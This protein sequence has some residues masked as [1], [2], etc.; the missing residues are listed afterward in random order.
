MKLM[1][2][3]RS[4]PALGV[5]PSSE[6]PDQRAVMTYM[7]EAAF[8]ATLT[9]TPDMALGADALSLAIHCDRSLAAVCSGVQA[10]LLQSVTVGV[11]VPSKQ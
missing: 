4:S 2:Y 6:P 7:P 5:D 8:Q 10:L 3:V 9:G 11:V 1:V